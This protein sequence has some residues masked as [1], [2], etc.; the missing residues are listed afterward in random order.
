LASI[1]SANDSR[2]W[3]SIFTAKPRPDWWTDVAIDF[4]TLGSTRG[5]VGV[6]VGAR[7]GTF[8][9]LIDDVRFRRL[10]VQ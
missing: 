8:E 6:F 3:L 2:T 5:L 4:E 7:A 1:G 9:L 10:A